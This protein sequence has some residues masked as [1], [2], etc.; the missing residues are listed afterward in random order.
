ME[1]KHSSS[2]SGKRKS[3]REKNR[4][5]AADR[6]SLLQQINQVR[7][8]FNLP[9]IK[10]QQGMDDYAG[11]ILSD[12]NPF[13]DVEGYVI[14]SDYH[15]YERFDGKS[16]PQQLVQ[17]WLNDSGKRP[18]LFAPGK[19]GTAVFLDTED[20]PYVVVAVISLFH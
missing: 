3:K 11:V 10:V 8:Y 1:R 15:F 2:H 14:L 4:Q 17:R 9:E 16:S 7:T 5:P 13:L 12:P 20:G 18:V 6:D 19:R